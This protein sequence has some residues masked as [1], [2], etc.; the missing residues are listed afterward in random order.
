[1]SIGIGIRVGNSSGSSYW[2]PRNI[3]LTAITGGIRIT[4]TPYAGMETEIW[5]SIDGGAY[6]LVTTSGLTIATYDYINDLGRTYTFKLRSKDGTIYSS[7]STPAS[8]YLSDVATTFIAHF[9]QLNLSNTIEGTVTNYDSTE[10]DT[11]IKKFGASSLKLNAQ[12][13]S[14]GLSQRFSIP[15]AAYQYFG[16]D[17]FTIDLWVRFFDVTLTLNL[18]RKMKDGVNSFYF[19]WYNNNTLILYVINT[20]PTAALWMTCP[21][22]PLVDTWYHIALVRVNADN[23]AT[24][25][26]IFIDGVSQ[27]LTKAGGS[28]NASMPNVISD[29]TNYFNGW[30][31]ELRISN[32]ARWTADFSPPTEAYPYYIPSIG[33]FAPYGIWER[34][35]IVM[36]PVNPMT[37]AD[38][39]VVK[40]DGGI[41]K[42]WYVHSNWVN[43]PNINYATSVD[44]KVFTNYASNPII[45]SR[46]R[47]SLIKVNGVYHLFTSAVMPSDT[48]GNETH[49]SLW[50]SNDG[51]NFTLDTENVMS[52]GG[53]GTW[54]NGAIFNREI[55]IEGTTWYMIYD[56]F[57]NL[58][59]HEWIGLATSVDGYGRQW[60]KY[61]GNPVIALPRSSGAFS[62]VKKIGSYY[63]TWQHDGV[64]PLDIYRMRSLDLI[65]WEQ[66][67]IAPVFK[68]KT[69][70]EG[71]PPGNQGM[72]A[73]PCF[74]EVGNQIYMYYSAHP[75]TLP[76]TVASIKLAI[77][78]MPI[79]DL[80]QTQEDNV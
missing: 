79:I 18:Y 78:D 16:V 8:L 61:A 65:T 9:N 69:T 12:D 74:V 5:V 15:N 32:I 54:D 60:T 80:I 7:Y 42:M 70:D 66:Y 58:G 21:F 77:A 14:L 34:Q 27:T 51:I 53:V 43:A 1:M 76:A 57:D 49:F 3:V 17:P 20:W 47:P 36:S 6:A 40:F 48:F 52:L 22:T 30:Y 73:E 75:N 46:R 59:S 19:Q 26:R 72:I 33:V 55:W 67:P 25:W 50:L 37:K 10:L 41:F 38:E 2:T 24:G 71:P 4:W 39:A 68:R 64:V 23:A 44:G 63:Y 28:W 11:T 45:S 29:A 13:P 35:G 62:P 31:D 56:A